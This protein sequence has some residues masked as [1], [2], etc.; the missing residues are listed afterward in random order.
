MDKRGSS[1]P[2]PSGPSE[3]TAGVPYLSPGGARLPAI[4]PFKALICR[5]VG[6]HRWY[7][8]EEVTGD[9][10]FGCVRC[11]DPSVVT[12]RHHP[13]PDPNRPGYVRVDRG[14][15]ERMIVRLEMRT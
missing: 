2:P 9:D 6:H 1:C 7:Y 8:K 5:L 12:D 3:A 14:F 4:R 11:Q 13:R 15:L 10:V